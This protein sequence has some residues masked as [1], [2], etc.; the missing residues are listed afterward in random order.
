M[1]YVSVPIGSPADFSPFT[2]NGAIAIVKRWRAVPDVMVQADSPIYTSKYT[3]WRKR[4]VAVIASM[5]D[6]GRQGDASDW[7]DAYEAYALWRLVGGPEPEQPR[8]APLVLTLAA[9]GDP[10]AAFRGVRNDYIVTLPGV[11]HKAI[12][13][14]LPVDRDYP[15]LLDETGVADEGTVVSTRKDATAIFK[16]A[17]LDHEARVVFLKVSER[18]GGFEAINTYD[19][20]YVSVGFIQFTTMEAGN[21]SLIRVLEDMKRRSKAEYKHY[22]QSYGVDVDD[23]HMLVV[24]DPDTGEVLHGPD[25]V[26]AVQQDKRLTAVFYHAGQGSKAFMESQVA[27]ARAQYY[28]PE[29][30][31]IIKMA[32]V[33]DY[34]DPYQPS[35]TYVYGDDAIA[36]A[37]AAVDAKNKLPWA[38]P[39]PKPIPVALS[40]PIKPLAVAVSVGL[41]AEHKREFHRNGNVGPLVNALLPTDSETRL[42]THVNMP[43]RHTDAET[44]QGEGLE[45]PTVPQSPPRSAETPPVT[46]RPLPD[47][48]YVSGAPTSRQIRRAA[49]LPPLTLANTHTVT[50]PQYMGPHYKLVVLPNLDG[51]YGDVF[52]TQ[53]GRTAIT[54]RCVQRGFDIGPSKQGLLAKFIE[55]VTFIA[56]GQKVTP[57]LLAAREADLIPIVQNRI[58]VL[59]DPDLSQPNAADLRFAKA[60][61]RKARPS[62]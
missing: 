6:Q 7:L 49:K 47:L 50:P 23:Q 17:A 26:E 11:A 57:R 36:Q 61:D 62:L 48:P 3:V 54:D 1:A 2:R 44:D 8:A 58:L 9:G 14:D 5:G 16:A 21:G 42:P 15:H 10:P 51:R 45:A 40:L 38:P 52:R 37:Q 28:A 20:G 4:A 31:F 12:F 32:K 33:V 56:N 13:H 29:H 19:K 39:A 22:F 27:Q 18:E 30:D 43:V 59:G 35:E 41:P 46:P 55:A 25:A 60:I 24:V 53:A 34:S